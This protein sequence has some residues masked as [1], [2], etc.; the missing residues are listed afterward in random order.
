MIEDNV[1]DVFLR[2]VSLARTSGLQTESKY[3]EKH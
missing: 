3:G 1:I 2:V